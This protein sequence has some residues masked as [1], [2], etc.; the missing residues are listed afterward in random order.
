[1]YLFTVAIG[2]NKVT[3]LEVQYK[4]KFNLKHLHKTPDTFGHVTNST[5]LEEKYRALDTAPVSH[6]ST[7]SIP[8]DPH[9]HPHSQRTFR[10]LLLQ[11]FN[12]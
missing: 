6:K 12:M 3:K 2:S 11:V 9:S 4:E 7:S 10:N 5:K 1:M 8:S